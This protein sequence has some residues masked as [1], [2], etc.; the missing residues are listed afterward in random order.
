LH[1]PLETYP[2]TLFDHSGSGFETGPGGNLVRTRDQA[3]QSR[4]FVALKNTME[5]KTPIAVVAGKKQVAKRKGKTPG[6]LRPFS[7]LFFDTNY[8]A[9][10][11]WE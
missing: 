8:S 3:E 7:F 11:V 10:S 1:S 2:L 9:S 5:K 4:N 6:T